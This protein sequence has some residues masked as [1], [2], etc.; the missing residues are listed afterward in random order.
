MQSK[1]KIFSLFV[2][3]LLALACKQGA[4]ITHPEPPVT[5]YRT[6]PVELVINGG[7]H[8]ISGAFLTPQFLQ[9]VREP[10]LMGRYFTEEEYQESRYR[11]AVVSQKFWERLG[12]DHK[13]IGETVV[14]NG[15]PYTVV[16]VMHKGFTF[17]EGVD[18]WLP[19]AVR[20]R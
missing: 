20:D 13:I 12:S 19:D 2:C 5:S 17:P 3:C 9:V 4:S 14:L 10:P 6:A 11:V 16:G 18:V 8:S 7:S 1:M 15:Q